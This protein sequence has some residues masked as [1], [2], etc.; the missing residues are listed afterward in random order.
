MFTWSS[1]SA[2]IAQRASLWCNDAFFALGWR[3]MRSVLAAPG[4]RILVYH[5]LDQRG[6]TALNG[7]FLSAARCEEQVRFLSENAHIVALSDYFS[8]NFHQNQ[9]TVAITFD[10]GQR[11]NRQYAVPVLDKYAAAATFFL[12]SAAGRDAE[13]LWMDFLDVATRLA[14][15]T[16]EIGGRRFTKKTW[17][18]TR[19]FADEN[20]RKLVDWAR[21][22]PWSFV[23]AM[24]TALLNAGAWN[25]AEHWTTYWELL[26]SAE[27]RE[28]AANP[29]VTIGAHGHTHQDLAYLSP[30]EARLELKYCKDFLEKTTG[31]PVP[32]LAY[33][34]GTYTRQL[35]EMA[36]Q[37]GFSQQLA[38]DFLFPEDHTDHRLRERMCMNPF[39]S[40]GNQWL[41]IKKGQY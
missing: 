9:F 23:Q 14:P 13:W 27:I 17:R 11:N 37:M 34:F 25:K 4:Q 22:S 12:T 24:E 5:G 21:Y 33:P 10:D 19:Y 30:E 39:I 29:R 31:Q 16:I 6:E 20:G 28:M 26:T 38:L 15:A 41:A 7:R 2:K 1:L 36:A 32:A 35:V 8:G 3:Q 40:D 18:H